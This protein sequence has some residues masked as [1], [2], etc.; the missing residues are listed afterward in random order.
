[1]SLA[2]LFVASGLPPSSQK[3]H[4]SPL[5][6]MQRIGLYRVLWTRQQTGVTCPDLHASHPTPG[7]DVPGDE[8]GG[9]AHG[10]ANAVSPVP[11]CFCTSFA[12]ASMNSVEGCASPTCVVY[13][14]SPVGNAM[15]A[16]W[17]LLGRL[18]AC[19]S[20]VGAADCEGEGC[21]SPMWLVESG[22][23]VASAMAGNGVLLGMLRTC[24]STVVAA[25]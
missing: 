19:L 14:G 1:M 2:L 5:L 13:A 7:H 21:A 20:T 8:P 25:D 24:L 3:N 4:C 23:P 15:S 18:G 17:V 12:T 6:P 11:I 22:S 16:N 10:P 9:L